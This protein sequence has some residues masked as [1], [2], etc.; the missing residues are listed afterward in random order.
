[1]SNS[2]L[3]CHCRCGCGQLVGTVSPLRSLC[4]SLFSH[5]FLRES[6]RNNLHK[7]FLCVNSRF[8]IMRLS[9]TASHHYN[10]VL[11]N[12]NHHVHSG[13]LSSIELRFIC[14]LCASMSVDL[15]KKER[16]DEYVVPSFL[17]YFEKLTRG[18]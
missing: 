18:R 7:S 4:S 8:A 17:Y 16:K 14:T 1:M 6:C 10:R 13:C 12:I 9:S 2:S 15:L 3:S 5:T 11:Q